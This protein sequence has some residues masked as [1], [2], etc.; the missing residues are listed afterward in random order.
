M[1]WQIKDL[2]TVEQNQSLSDL[3]LS[4]SLGRSEDSVRAIRRYL[5]IVKQEQRR[6]TAN[7]REHVAMNLNKSDK[8]LSIEL[9][10]TASEVKAMRVRYGYKKR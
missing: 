6:W 9:G 4:Y 2:R 5:G 7:E 8:Q 10:R 1:L 3:A